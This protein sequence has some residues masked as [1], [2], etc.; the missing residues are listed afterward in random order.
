MFFLA[1]TILQLRRRRR[2]SSSWSMIRHDSRFVT[3]HYED[4]P[5]RA[6]KQRRRR[7]RRRAKHLRTFLRS[8]VYVCTR[9]N[10][11]AKREVNDV[12]VAHRHYT[13]YLMAPTYVFA[14]SR[15]LGEQ[16]KSLERIGHELV[17]YPF[18]FI[19]VN[20]PFSSI[21]FFYCF[22]FISHIYKRTRMHD[23]LFVV[24]AVAHNLSN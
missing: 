24:R 22:F 6:A 18:L 5:E 12:C 2:R 9:V 4:V 23:R 11:R 16:S 14:V 13:H 10:R 17:L 15:S 21:F 1:L 3:R 7:R 20:H 19:C 8:F